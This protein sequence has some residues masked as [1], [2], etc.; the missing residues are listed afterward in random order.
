MPG[1]RPTNEPSNYFALGKQANKDEPATTFYFFKH[2]DGTGLELD[3]QTEAVREG[4][5]GQEVGFVYKSAIS[6]DGDVIANARPERAGRGAAWT[7]G[8]DKVETAAG[9]ASGVAQV[10]ISTPTSTIPYLT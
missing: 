3:E 2:L 8:A 5:D 4:G 6:F 1:G 9:E 7:L 10:H